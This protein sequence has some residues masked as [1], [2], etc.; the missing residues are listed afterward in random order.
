[1]NIKTNDFVGNILQNK[2][3]ASCY[4]LL[5]GKRPKRRCTPTCGAAMLL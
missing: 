2:F 4:I 1:V 3:Y 5:S